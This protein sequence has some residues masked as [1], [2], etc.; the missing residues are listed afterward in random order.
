MGLGRTWGVIFGLIALLIL[1]KTSLAGNPL[2]GAK[3][4]AMGGAFAAVADDPSAIAHNPA[5]L[6]ILKGTNVYNGIS[7]VSLS[8]NYESP[9]GRSE[10]TSF[11]LFFPP[12]AFLTSNLGFENF[13]FGLGIYSPFGI[14]GRKWSDTGLTRYASTRSTIATVNI[15][16]T[17]AWRI[18]PQLSL[19]VG[20][21]ILYSSNQMARMVNQSIFAFR[22]A[23]LSFKGSGIG[24]GGNFG[25]LLFPEGK[26]SFAFAYRSRIRVKQRGTLALEAI[27]P[28]LQ[29]LF[30]SGVFRTKASMVMEFPHTFIWGA[31]YRPSPRMTLSLE[32]N[33]FLWSVLNQESLNL[34]TQVPAAKLTNIP[35]DFQWKDFLVIMVGM[36][37]KLSKRFSVRGG[38]VYE[39]TMVPD[40]TLT[41][42]EPDADQHYI[43]VGFG[44]RPGKWTIDAFYAIGFYVDRNV[45]NAILSGEYHSLD[46]IG[47]VSIGYRF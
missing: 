45:D 2:E 3:A 11:Q 1:A 7:L 20:L 14:G 6:T 23:R 16:P 13:A 44:Y 31:A 36:D 32:I 35:L 4:A 29:S 27:A 21:D 8:S 47:G 34:K 43:T 5:G 40:N 22:D 18:L 17:V 9:E 33:W 46:N 26:F 30:G 42:G 24:I 25:I 28:P 19:G 37:Y 12:H 15:N 39:Q 41:P 38:Y 10:T